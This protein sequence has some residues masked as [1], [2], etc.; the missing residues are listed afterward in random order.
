MRMKVPYRNAY[1]NFPRRGCFSGTRNT[2]TPA[3]TSP[4]AS[5]LLPRQIKSTV[6]PS[7]NSAFM[8]RRGR[9]SNGEEEKVTIATRFPASLLMAAVG[10]LSSDV[11]VVVRVIVEL[12]IG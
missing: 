5:F 4:L 6:A 9:G 1:S 10:G 2:F 8:D 3:G 12:V 7:A 11:V